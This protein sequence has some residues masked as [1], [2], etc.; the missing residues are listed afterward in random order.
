M[1]K[2]VFKKNDVVTLLVF[3]DFLQKQ[4]EDLW[5]LVKMRE[6]EVDE[7]KERARLVRNHSDLSCL[8]NQIE[9]VIKHTKGIKKLS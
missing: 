9:P 2:K 4:L 1:K 8:V 5:A 6:K 3:I 7:M